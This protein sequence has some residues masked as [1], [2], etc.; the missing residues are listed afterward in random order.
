L[1][2]LRLFDLLL[3]AL[4]LPLFLLA[5]WPMT[6]YAAACGAWLV[7]RGIQFD[8]ER[9]VASQLQARNRRGALTLTAVSTLAR[10]WLLTL[11]ILLVGKLADRADGLAAAL[12]CAALVT[13]SLGGQALSRV[14]GPP[15]PQ[16]EPS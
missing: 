11:S 2:F 10:L 4:A 12:L 16:G 13:A 14:A 7:Q 5:G 9:R 1:S 15:A 8:S 3:L 6:G